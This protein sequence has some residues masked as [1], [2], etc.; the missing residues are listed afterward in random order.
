[1]RAFS[2]LMSCYKGDNPLLLKKAIES[3]YSSTVLPT[4]FI[5]VEDGRLNEELYKVINERKNKY[6]SIKIVKLSENVGL[7]SALDVGL[8]HCSNELVARM[9]S[10]DLC[11]DSRFEL[12]LEKFDQN[13]ELDVVGGLIEEFNSEESKYLRKNRIVP[14]FQIEILAYSRS[15]NPVNHVTVMFK[16]SIV[17]GLGSYESFPLFE[18]YFL[19]LKLL[20]SKALFY[21]IQKTLVLVRAGED[22]VGRRYGLSYANKELQFYKKA[23]ERGYI[24]TLVFLKAVLIRLPLRLLP[25]KVLEFLYYNVFRR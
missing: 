5:L 4:E 25:K 24:S 12:Q 8:R 15:R 1:M 10:D 22:M 11:V 2:V 7:G 3:V 20:D 13:S 19:W 23:Y 14:E 21:N 16:K 9:D 18:D 6:N 17:L